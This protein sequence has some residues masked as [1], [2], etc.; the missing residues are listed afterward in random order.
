[1]VTKKV[2]LVLKLADKEWNGKVLRKRTIV[3]EDDTNGELTLFP[4]MDE[5]T[6][7]Q[8]LEHEIINGN[9]G[10]EVKLPRKGGKT[11]GGGFNKKT[12]EQE[13]NLNAIAITKSAIEGGLK[14]E[15]WKGFYIEAYDFFKNFAAN[16]DKPITEGTKDDLPWDNE[17][18][19]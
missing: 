5:V 4:E 11:G 17:N 6:E 1:M 2:K 8:D 14:L 3:F 13:A 10:L 15:D 19:N 12:P 7:G 16:P 9:Y 18:S